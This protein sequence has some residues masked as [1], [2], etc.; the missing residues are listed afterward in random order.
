M[1]H[2]SRQFQ[3]GSAALSTLVVI[4]AISIALSAWRWS[5]VRA[6]REV[7]ERLFSWQPATPAIFDPALV[8]ELPEPA[9]RYFEFAI[10]PGTPLVT[11][12][13]ISMEGDFSLGDKDQPGYMPMRARQ[14]IAAPHGFIWQVQAGT[15]LRLSGSDGALEGTSWS[16]FWLYGFIPV[17]RAGDNAD[18][19]R[20]A[21]GRY[22]AEAVFWTPAALLP[23]DNIQWQ[24]I[25]KD[26][27]RV[28]VRYKQMV[29]AVD[30][31]LDEDGKPRKVIFQR[32]SD[33]NPDKVYQLQPF[34]GYLSHF[35][36][37][38]G[39]QLPTRIEAGNFFD[40]DNYFPFFRVDVAAIDFTLPPAL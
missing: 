11:V 39:Y 17:A 16:R 12:A 26:T 18:H 19:A 2:F 30:L 34:G 7:V 36:N 33:A 28:T 32:W 23:A 4:A 22:I 8:A 21:F 20:A 29:Q 27:A 13:A 38:S 24:A 31:Y 35:R 37:F 3:K 10:A 14:V 1:L 9:R 25:D 6:E 15:S 5:E 40:T